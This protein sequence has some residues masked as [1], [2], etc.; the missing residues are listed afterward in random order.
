MC[1]GKAKCVNNLDGGLFFFSEKI[2]SKP[3]GLLGSL[4]VI[5]HP[6]LTPHIFIWFGQMHHHSTGQMPLQPAGGIIQRSELN[7]RKSV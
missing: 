2:V 3:K 1:L 7:Q 5:V 6:L 4:N